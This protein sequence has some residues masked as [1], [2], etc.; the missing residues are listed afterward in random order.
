MLCTGIQDDT[1][2][3]IQVYEGLAKQKLSEEEQ[4]CHQAFRLTSGNSDTT[5]EWYKDRVEERVEGTCMWF[6][7][8]KHFHE[9][10]N[11]ESGPLLVS[12]DPGCGKSV[13]AKYLIDHALPRSTTICYFF[14]KDQDQNTV[15]QALCALL[16]QLFSQKPSLIEYALPQFRKDGPGMANSTKSLWEI[17]RNATKDPRA[18]PMIIVLDALDECTKS[19]FENLVQNVEG[20]FRCDQSGQGRLKYLLT[21]RPYKQIVSEFRDL[22]RAFPN[23][24]IPGEEHSEAIS[25][26]VDQVISHRI[27]KL[28]DNIP[29]EIKSHLE[30]KLQEITHRTYLWLYLVFDHLKEEDFIMTTTGAES[31]IATLPASINEAYEQILNKSKKHPMVRKALCI[32]LAARRPLT[33]SEMK[34]AVNIEPHSKSLYKL[35]SESEENFKSRLRSWCGLFISIYH[36]KIYLLHQTAREF[37][38]ADSAY[39]TTVTPGLHW[40]RSI[41]AQDAQAVLAE[42]C[43][44]YLDFFNFDAGLRKNADE[45][46][47]H[48]G[49]SV[50]FFDYSAQHWGD[51]FREAGI[52][53]GAAILPFA[54]RICDPNSRCYSTW[55]GIYWMSKFMSPTED[56]TDLMVA[57]Y[58]GHEAVVRLLLERDTAVD[59]KER[60]GRTP[61][62]WAATNGHEAVVRLLLDRGAAVDT[63]DKEHKTPLACAADEGHK[64]VVQLLLDRGAAI[65]LR[66]KKNRTPLACAAKKGHEAVVQ[67]LLDRDAVVDAKDNYDKTPLACAADEGHEAIVR[68]L[69][70]RGAAVDGQGDKVWTPLEWAAFNRHAAIARLLLDRGAVIDTPCREIHSPKPL[71]WAAYSGHES[72][73]QL[74]LDRG[75][76][77]DLNTGHNGETPLLM[78]AA[79]G[80]EAVVRLLL[81]RGATVDAKDNDGVTPLAS[82]VRCGHKAIVRLLLDSGAAIDGKDNGGW[83]PLASAALN[84][85]EAVVRLL[86]DRGAAV[87]T[88]NNI[89]G[90]MPPWLAVT[91]R[92]EVIVRLLLDR[93]AVVDAKD[94]YG[95]TPLLHA[96]SNGQE[97][98]V[99]LLTDRGADVDAEGRYVVTPLWSAVMKGHEAIVRK[100]LDRGASTDGG[101]YAGTTPLTFAAKNGNEALVRL[102]LDRGAS[103]DGGKYPGM[104]PLAR[105]ADEGH[106]AIVRLLLDS[107]AFTDAGDNHH[108]PLLCAARHGHEAIV[109]LL[110]DRGAAVDAKDYNGLTPLARAARGGHE[111]VVRLLL[112]RGTTIDAGGRSLTPLA[113]AIHRG[114]EA[115]VRL[116]LDRGATIAPG[117]K[118]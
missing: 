52:V 101:K 5:Y 18:G 82:A 34:V 3:I 113:H 69:L 31:A 6:L 79:K 58:F 1:K 117:A 20:Q 46:V 97:A 104:T 30:R 87:D 55:L 23:I 109:R 54:L 84:G 62:W 106:E 50:A 59:T 98:I 94:R 100:L 103:I 29:M 108:G 11:Q 74:L 110:L 67:L 105:A 78:A 96:A 42:L 99:Q 37:L 39:L 80:Y 64:A 115:V 76:A 38:L 88:K 114:H 102:L 57:S 85:D 14:F 91:T 12:A 75:A 15:C 56:F 43:V 27:N 32:I 61:L 19:E 72:V 51:H 24:H 90:S 28:S 95:E 48:L 41:A 13:L 92:Y 73:V 65:D 86:L 45:N 21:C 89:N 116:L 111:A 36:G 118:A 2:K 77:G 70:D 47:C 16:H 71:W 93:G 107:G 33:L 60:Y 17:L 53:D 112:D 8:H 22:L 66:D 35:N 10:L 44:L 63:G 40:H 7:N 25:Q 9:W 49:A 83:T 68:L 4:K 81:D 26:E